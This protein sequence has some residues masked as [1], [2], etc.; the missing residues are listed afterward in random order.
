[1]GLSVDLILIGVNTEKAVISGNLIPSG[2]VMP[3]H[4]R[5][6]FNFLRQNNDE[7]AKETWG[8]TLAE[9][10]SELFDGYTGT[11]TDLVYSSS[12]I[13][14]EQEKHGLCE[15]ELANL[16]EA[17]SE[18]TINFYFSGIVS[19]EAYK[20]RSVRYGLDEPPFL[21]EI[22]AQMDLFKPNTDAGSMKWFVLIEGDDL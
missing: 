20:N 22:T 15:K 1:M 12:N 8:E 13:M 21:K 2:E 3:Y 4:L 9:L 10:D 14:Y 16:F 5:C 11:R 18:H 19:L 6:S 17:L 7:D